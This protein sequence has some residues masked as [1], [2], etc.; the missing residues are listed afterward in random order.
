MPRTPGRW[1]ADSPQT[2]GFRF[3]DATQIR[4]D[5]ANPVYTRNALGDYSLNR[6]AAGAETYHFVASFGDEVMRILQ[7]GADFK[8]DIQSQFGG[9]YG[10]KDVP[11]VPPY[12]WGGSGQAPWLTPPTQ[13]TPKGSRPKDLWLVYNVGV[14]ALT[15]AT[16]TLSVTTY[17]NNA[18]LIVTPVTLSA[19]TIPLTVQANNY[20]FI[21]PV[22]TPAFV[23]T[24]LSDLTAE[25]TIAMAST[26]TLKLYGI[27]MH[28]DLNFN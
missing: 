13:G 4:P 24:D 2:G 22:A 17:N 10:P 5:S 3:I 28:F 6:T 20:T 7:T 16:L 23:N 27:G 25:L 11:G 21:V 14:L 26:G 8:S 1:N 12:T 15:S 18:V 19:A 9:T